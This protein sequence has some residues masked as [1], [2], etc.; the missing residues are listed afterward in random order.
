MGWIL[1]LAVFVLLVILTAEY[2][3]W[4]Q[5]AATETNPLRDYLKPLPGSVDTGREH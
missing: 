1:V 2:S 3:A 4:V 5:R